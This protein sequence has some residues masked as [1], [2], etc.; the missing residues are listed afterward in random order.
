MSAYPEISQQYQTL[1][2]QLPC[3]IVFLDAHARVVEANRWFTDLLTETRSQPPSLIGNSFPL[4]Y[5]ASSQDLEAM[6]QRLLLGKRFFVELC[7]LRLSPAEDSIPLSISGVPHWGELGEVAGGMILIVDRRRE[8][9]LLEMLQQAQALET[10]WILAG[11]LTGDLRIL[12]DQLRTSLENLKKRLG[13]AVGSRELLTVET[14]V[15]ET[16]KLTE[17]LI[18]PSQPVSQHLQSLDLN[19]A[20]R[21]VT[22]ILSC[23]FSQNVA[24]SLH[25][26]PQLPLVHLDEVHLVRIF[27]N[28][29][30]NAYEAMPHGGTI[31]IHTGFS[32]VEKAKEL[33]LSDVG[34]ESIWIAV[35]DEGVGI[36]AENR[37]KIFDPFFSEKLQRQ[38]L[39]MG[40]YLVQ[41][42][43]QQYG[44]SVRIESQVGRGSTFSMFFP[45]A[46]CWI[47]QVLQRAAA[48]GTVLF[49]DDEPLLRNLGKQF[50]ES[51][52]Y[53][54]LLAC[55]GAEA[56][57]TYRHSDENIDL[58][59]LD[60]V[61]PDKRGTEVLMDILAIDP[62]ARVLLTSGSH[63]LDIALSTK[64]L[65]FLPKP[66]R[67]KG[68][69]TCVQNA[70]MGKPVLQDLNEAEETADPVME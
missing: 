9:N 17:S 30:I 54:A 42:I 14:T 67:L 49:V 4:Q 22:N 62:D 12:L 66:Y 53:R 43:V 16:V 36:P 57:E 32:D 10:V 58:V 8:L 59:I 47:D 13:N 64:A 28:L 40:L 15:R 7:S 35:Q 11:G 55:N 39:G 70:M 46:V 41:K 50:L 44:G 48:M 68:F 63:N 65:G 27:M 51:G 60:I 31:S 29:C 18:I 34:R 52:G 21:K 38:G 3:G 33:G 5:M 20:V 56:V 69:L 1:M 23:S 24:F 61:L 25:L 2:D 37:E 6:L 26:D 45:A 19:E